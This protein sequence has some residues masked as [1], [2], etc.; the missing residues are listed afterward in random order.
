MPAA[1]LTEIAARIKRIDQTIGDMRQVGKR[2]IS[3]SCKTRVSSNKRTNARLSRAGNFPARM[4]RVGASTTTIPRS[5][6]S[7]LLLTSAS[8]DGAALS[9]TLA[10]DAGMRLFTMSV[11]LRSD[12]DA[13]DVRLVFSADADGKQHVRYLPVTVNTEWKHYR[14]RVTDIPADQLANAKVRI[15]IRGPGKLWIDDI[16]IHQNRLSPEDLQADYKNPFR[17]HRRL[18][19]RP[20]CRLPATARQLLGTIAVRRRRVECR[21]DAQPEKDGDRLATI[22]PT[23][24]AD[25][26]GY[27]TSATNSVRSSAGGCPS[28]NSSRR[29]RIRVSSR[30][31]S[32]LQSV[33]TPSI[34]SIPNISPSFEFASVMPSV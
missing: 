18:E 12:Q 10:V 23:V 16:D 14:F 20:L 15:E 9:S 2:R 29:A 6:G 19:R 25:E 1:S 31:A 7:S 33:S 8:D 26:A 27:R 4:Q 3:T 17:N 5:G 13:A 22:F 24:A 32:A 21:C 34:R 28:V 30:F 11:W